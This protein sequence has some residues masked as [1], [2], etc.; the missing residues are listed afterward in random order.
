M[1]SPQGVNDADDL[2]R[3][4]AELLH[5]LLCHVNLIPLNATPNC[6]YQPTS[7]AQV[8][9]FQEILVQGGIQTT[10]RLRRGIEI[11]AGCGQLRG[12]HFGQGDA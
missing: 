1:P 9:R 10:V 11:Q 6:P 5:G 4:T 3:R 8:M 12:Q 2:A 7:R